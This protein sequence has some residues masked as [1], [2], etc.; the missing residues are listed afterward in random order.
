[1]WWMWTITKNLGKVSIYVAEV[2]VDALYE[3]ILQEFNNPFF[4]AILGSRLL[5]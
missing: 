2:A 4:W 3:R 1:M 5:M